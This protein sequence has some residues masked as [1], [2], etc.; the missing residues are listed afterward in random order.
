MRLALSR[1]ELRIGGI[2]RRYSIPTDDI[3][4]VTSTRIRGRVPRALQVI[5]HNPDAPT[6]IF[7]LSAHPAAWFKTFEVF[8]IKTDDPQKMLEFGAPDITIEK[9]GYIATWALIAAVIV[10]AVLA[11]LFGLK[12]VRP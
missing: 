1:A 4:C 6:H 7:F 3:D 9:W 12:A 2:F 5:H 11:L 10:G 8:G